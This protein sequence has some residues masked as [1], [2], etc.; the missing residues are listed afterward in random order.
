MLALHGREPLRKEGLFEG[1]AL[2]I[3]RR[4]GITGNLRGNASRDG[5][6]SLLRGRLKKKNLDR[7]R[8]KKT[9][10]VG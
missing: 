9:G 5:G 10:T 6:S 4:L 3:R 7:K 8:K 2:Y 1:G